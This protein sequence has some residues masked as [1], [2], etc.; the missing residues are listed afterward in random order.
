MDNVWSP[1]YVCQSILMMTA[2]ADDNN[3]NYDDN[4]NGNSLEVMEIYKSSVFY[5]EIVL[6][7][8]HF[9]IFSCSLTFF[10]F[11]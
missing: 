7:L 10:S 11:S 6:L 3:G 5:K 9:Y 1:L 8:L 4:Y 2:A